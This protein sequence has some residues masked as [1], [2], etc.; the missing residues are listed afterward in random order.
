MRC[1]VHRDADAVGVCRS[2]GRGL[3]PACAAEVGTALACLRRC[4]EDVRQLTDALRRQ[5][6]MMRPIGQQFANTATVYRVV[7]RLLL[8]IGALVVVLGGGLALWE[9]TRFRPRMVEVVLELGLAA[10]GLLVLAVGSRL[11]TA[12]VNVPPAE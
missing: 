3:C 7:R 12:P 5:V 2:C 8:A 10:I 4:E 1:Y 11:P 9:G 6:Q